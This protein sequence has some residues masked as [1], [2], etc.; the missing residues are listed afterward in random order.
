MSHIP[1]ILSKFADCSRGATA[2]VFALSAIP[3]IAAAGVAIDQ[4]RAYFAKSALQAATDAAALSAASTAVQS[5]QRQATAAAVFGACC[6]RR[7]APCA[8]RTRR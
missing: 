6:P 4:S 2:V 3:F 1:A 8:G 7:R 5:A